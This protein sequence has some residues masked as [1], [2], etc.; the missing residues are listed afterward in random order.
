MDTASQSGGSRIRLL[1]ITACGLAL[2]LFS[3]LAFVNNI[4]VVAGWWARFN[5][6]KGGAT[7]PEAPLSGIIPWLDWAA[8]DYSCIST[9]IPFA[10]FTLCAAGALSL[11]R[12]KGGKSESFPFFKASDRLNIA[13]GLIGT[14]WGII[15]IGY[16][17]MDSVQM[18]DLMSCLHTA[19]FSTLV[20][21]VWVFLI[22]HMLLRPLIQAAARNCGAMAE[23]EDLLSSVIDGLKSDAESL[24]ASWTEER[25][26]FRD[27][28]GALESA[29]AELKSLASTGRETAEQLSGGIG[30]A[31]SD[32]SSRLASA[33]E[34]I[35]KRQADY[36]D[37]MAR[38]IER[39]DESFS[40]RL[41]DF[42]ERAARRLEALE[43][44]SSA[45]IRELEGEQ[46]K[47][48]EL[49]T[50]SSSVIASAGEAMRAINERLSAAEAENLRL[51]AALEKERRA[52]CGLET[53]L[54]EATS[55]A[56]TENA[57][58]DQAEE[59]LRKIRAAFSQV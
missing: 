47:F 57:R 37:Q 10:G 4:S 11:L 18:A 17:D 58:A 24:R 26:A 3:G 20:A 44:A 50:E 19:L 41:A 34:Q 27:F 15:V 31:V 43:K 8:V 12:G 42:E 53:N 56:N 55:K 14:L 5:A 7:P 28:S 21:V 40:K 38:R 39:I 29:G 9:F 6:A 1:F 16:Y 33:A 54:A 35:E 25:K 2:A 13:L 36:N 51:G 23:E 45:R 52:V 59:T 32:L 46:A 30:A 22:D 48:A 49:L